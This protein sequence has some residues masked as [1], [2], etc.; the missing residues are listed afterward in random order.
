MHVKL[1]DGN[2]LLHHSVF[3]EHI[4]MVNYL[5]DKKVDV[6]AKNNYGDTPLHYAFQIN[7]MQVSKYT[8]F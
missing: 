3:F 4:E 2:S 6:N 7:N 5:I 8:N 1:E